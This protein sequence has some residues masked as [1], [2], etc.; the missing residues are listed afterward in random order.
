[1]SG[2]IAGMISSLKNNKLL[3]KKRKYFSKDNL[4]TT[5]NEVPQYNSISD[6]DLKKLRKKLQNE[7]RVIKNRKIVVYTIIGIFVLAV[8]RFVLF[9]L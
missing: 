8:F 7:Q 1:M 5:G 9:V 3:V 6:L 2:G 4:Y